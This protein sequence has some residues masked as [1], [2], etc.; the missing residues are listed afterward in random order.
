MK[1]WSCHSSLWMTICLLTVLKHIA[2]VQFHIF[3]LYRTVI[4]IVVIVV[5]VVVVVVTVS[6]SLVSFAMNIPPTSVI[7][8]FI[9]LYIQ[10]YQLWS[11]MS[12]VS[13]VMNYVWRK[14]SI[15][16][17][18]RNVMIMYISYSLMSSSK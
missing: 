2:Q 14:I 5:L 18:E 11:E 12:S 9:R 17:R 8:V 10:L 15:W 6:P 7:T 16:A 4:C 3:I 1:N 13:F